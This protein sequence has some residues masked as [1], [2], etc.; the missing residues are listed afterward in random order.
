LPRRHDP[1]P[2]SDDAARRDEPEQ[3]EG[4]AD[5][6]AG[7]QQHEDDHHEDRD[8]GHAREGSEARQA[9]E[10]GRASYD[11]PTLDITAFK[12]AARAAI[13]MPAVF[14]FADKVIGQPQVS[15]FAAFGSFAMLVLVDV[16]GSLRTRLT[17]YLALALVGAA[18]ITVGT[19][20]S[21]NAWLAGG[22]LGGG[23]FVT[24]LS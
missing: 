19:L 24:A 17:A 15:L 3:L 1:R 16:E 23:R 8:H 22:S 4:E 7:Q 6:R 14:A 13:V 9:D 2:P 11:R 21:Q 18:F 20:C 5:Q 12:H 10:L